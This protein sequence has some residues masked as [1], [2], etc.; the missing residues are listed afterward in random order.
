MLGSYARYKVLEDLNR[1][2]SICGGNG[3]NI[4]G[5]KL[6]LSKDGSRPEELFVHSPP[7]MPPVLL[8]SLISSLRGYSQCHMV[9]IIVSFCFYTSS[10]S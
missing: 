9:N 8:S 2:R 6:S 1:S 4:L 5:H 10:A 7:Q 3:Q